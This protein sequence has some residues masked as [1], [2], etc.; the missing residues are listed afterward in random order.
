MGIVLE[1]HRLMRVMAGQT[2][3]RRLAFPEAGALLEVRWLMPHVPWVIP[4]HH[5]LITGKAVAVAT[6]LV[7]LCG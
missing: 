3:E 5:V 7:Q 1:P 2:G 4:V 6:E